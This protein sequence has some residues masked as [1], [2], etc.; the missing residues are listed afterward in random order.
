[1][2]RTTFQMPEEGPTVCSAGPSQAAWRAPGQLPAGLP[3]SVAVKRQ[4]PAVPEAPA[5]KANKNAGQ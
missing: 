2:F 5:E 3:E 1:M 4:R